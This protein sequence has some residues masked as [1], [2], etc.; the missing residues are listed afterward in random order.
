MIGRRGSS[1]YE[2]SLTHLP[3]EVSMEQS[4][5]GTACSQ[6]FFIQFSYTLLGNT[7]S[8][9]TNLKVKFKVLGFLPRWGSCL[10]LLHMGALPAS[11]C[12]KASE[13]VDCSFLILSII[14]FSLLR[15]HFKYRHF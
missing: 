7:N 9:E 10:D 5:S 8:Q 12:S 4:A 2:Q 1:L 11:L 14:S 13:L 6:L 15:G 3:M